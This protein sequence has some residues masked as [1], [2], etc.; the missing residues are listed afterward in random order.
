MKARSH[1]C[2]PHLDRSG[3]AIGPALLLVLILLAFATTARALVIIP[4]WDS[5]ITNDA[6]AA[7]IESTINMAIEFLE[8]RFADPITVS[9]EFEEKTRAWG[10]ILTITTTFPTA[11]SSPVSKAMPPPP[12]TPMPWLIFLPAR[13][14][15]GDRQRPH[16]CQDRQSRGDRPDRL[17]LSSFPADLTA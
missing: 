12:T 16:S 14:A 2:P 5:S 11:N 17:W 3:R 4:V 15:P 13:P 10:R 6:N 9:I 7:T 1:P 8:A